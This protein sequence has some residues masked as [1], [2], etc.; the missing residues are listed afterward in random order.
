MSDWAI[1]VR[2][3]ALFLIVVSIVNIA[4]WLYLALLRQPRSSR[5]WQMVLSAGFVAGCAFR[6]FLP[7]ADVQRIC[8]YPGFSSSVLVGRSVATIAELCLMIQG[9]LYLHEL[10]S[11]VGDRAA[12]TLSF[13]IVPFI[14]VAEICSWYAVVTTNYIGNTLEE[15][16]WTLSASLLARGF[17]LVRRRSTGDR[18]IRRLLGGAAL[19]LG[20]YVLFMVRVDVPMYFFRWRADQAAG[21][22]YL[23]FADGIHDLATRWVVTHAWSDWHDEVAWMALYFSIAV[24]MSL[25]L[26]RAPSLQPRDRLHGH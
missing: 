18:Q 3:W 13:F 15:S 17:L 2:I 19:L 24:W 8:L 20:G 25:Y 4:L 14:A 10:A 9:A 16:I 23:T 21:R 11:A 12:R 22:A 6:S 26:I 7:R 1:Q 5:R